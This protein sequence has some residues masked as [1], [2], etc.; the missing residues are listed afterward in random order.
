MFPDQIIRVKGLSWC[1]EEFKEVNINNFVKK[2]LCKH[3]NSSPGTRESIASSLPLVAFRSAKDDVVPDY[4][5][6]SGNNEQPTDNPN[7]VDHE[8]RVQ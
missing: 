6:D 4:P 7:G 3:H 1:F 2:V 5:S 8:A